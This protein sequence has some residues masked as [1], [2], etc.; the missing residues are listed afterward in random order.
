MP[1]YNP[2]YEPEIKQEDPPTTPN[3]ALRQYN[4]LR[5][6]DDPVTDGL[7]GEGAGTSSKDRPPGSRAQKKS[8]QLEASS[9][10]QKASIA[11][12]TEFVELY[13]KGIEK[14]EHNRKANQDA[15]TN[16][17]A[18]IERETAMKIQLSDRREL[19]RL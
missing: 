3:A 4:A 18:A 5:A 10:S 8:K 1:K 11:V 7:S 2:Q 17:A 14:R 12:D 15:M 16:M 6:S 19:N 9:S 13:K